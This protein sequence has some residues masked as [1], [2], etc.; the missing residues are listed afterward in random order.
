[1]NP[2][3]LA[4]PLFKESFDS[5][6][7]G[8]PDLRPVDLPSDVELR[9]KGPITFQTKFYTS[10]YGDIRC[11]HISSPRIEIINF[12]FFPHPAIA[13]PVYAMEFVVFGKKPIVAVI[14]LKGLAADPQ[15]KENCTQIMRLAHAH[16]P[17]LTMAT[18]PP[19]WFSEC[20][21]GEDFFSR[22]QQLHTMLSAKQAHEFV[23]SCLYDIMPKANLYSGDD[24]VKH[25]EAIRFYKDHHRENSPGLPFLNRTFGE[26]WTEHFLKNYLFS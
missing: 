9:K 22:P 24:A 23:C 13:L 10:S 15:L 18:D 2:T 19:G 12:F 26:E 17:E 8:A 3:K 16:F 4:I 11:V 25:A 14:D 20:R 7:T 6:Q 21:S 1:M 5:V